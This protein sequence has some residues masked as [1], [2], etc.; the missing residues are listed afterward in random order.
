MHGTSSWLGS[1]R[2]SLGLESKLEMFGSDQDPTFSFLK[3]SFWNGG[4]V[5]AVRLYVTSDGAGRL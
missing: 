5:I 2:P 1:N 3:L 4:G